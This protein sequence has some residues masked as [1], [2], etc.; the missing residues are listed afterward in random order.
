R[1]TDEAFNDF[2]MERN[3]IFEAFRFGFGPEGMTVSG[4]LEER[5]ATLHGMYI[6][7]H[8]PVNALRFEIGEVR[9]N[10]VELPD[11]TRAA[12]QAEYDFTFEPGKLVSGLNVKQL[13]YE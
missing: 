2:L 8:E 6:L 7:E 13:L 11:T 3:P 4:E 10:E 1:L 12:M 5:E 9:F